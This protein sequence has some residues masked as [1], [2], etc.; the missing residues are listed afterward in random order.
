MALP[1][2]VHEEGWLAAE[3]PHHLLHMLDYKVRGK[4]R[5][6]RKLRLAAVGCLHAIRGQLD[7]DLR[8]VV[9]LAEGYTD[10]RASFADMTAAARVLPWPR[11]GVAWSNANAARDTAHREAWLALSCVPSSVLQTTTGGLKLGWESFHVRPRE[12]WETCRDTMAAVIRDVFGN[13]FRRV[14]FAKGW[15]TATAVGLAR[16]MYESRD[17]GAMPILADAL[18]EAGCDD[19]DVLAHCRSGGRHVRGC[20]VVDL[21]LGLK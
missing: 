15:R 10:G 13:P 9:E 12:E 2:W 11:D 3:N 4:A 17:F 5:S 7:D 8:R 18:E 16:G 21:V 19:P 6:R 14:S 20:W 1:N